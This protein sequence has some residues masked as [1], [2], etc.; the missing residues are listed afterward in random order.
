M[1]ETRRQPTQERAK[2]RVERILAAASELIAETGSDTVR[3]TEVAAR[4]GIP[5]GSLY[6]YFPDKAAI[7]RMLALRFMERVR[8]GLRDGL[9]GI[10]GGEEALA[11]V[12][13][14]LEGYYAVF[15]TEP[16]VRDIWSG[17]Q[18][19]KALQEIDIE[20][21]RANGEL[22][23]AALKSLVAKRDHARFAASC[24]LLMQLSGAAVRLAIG[25]EREEG[26]RLMIEYRRMV[27]SELNAFLGG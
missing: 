3:M 15:L 1:T 4:A 8:D 19:D 20:D 18:S 2:A 16:V 11:R 9:A 12:D 7:L 23:F 26:D 24:F 10:G 21:S 25:V 17:T 6:Q 22:V 27:R 14:I 13:A 5:I